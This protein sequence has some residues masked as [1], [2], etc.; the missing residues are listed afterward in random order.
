MEFETVSKQLFI[1][2]SP[3]KI[4]KIKKA[5]GNDFII[6]A[7]F[8]HV[9][10]LEKKELG[11]N[12]ESNFEPNYIVS[13]DKKNVVSELKKLGK[14]CKKV[15]LASDYDREGESIAWHLFQVMGLKKEN[16][17]RTV[18]TE[19]TPKAL[20]NAIK[21]PTDIDIDMFY[22]QQ[23][24]RVIDRLIG[25]LITPVLWKNFHS[26]FEKKISLSAGRVQTVALRIVKER[27]DEIKKFQ[28]NTYF[29]ITGQFEQI[30]D[31]DLNENINEK[32][33][34]S[35][36]LD[37]C[38]QTEF[39]ISDI[40]KK[41][42]IRKPSAPFITSSL[43]Q[44]A[45][46]KIGFSPKKTMSV[47]QRLYENGYITYMRT[48]SKILSNDA[49]EMISEVINSKYGPEYLNVTSYDKKVKGSQEAHEAIRP[50]DVKVEEVTDLEPDDNKLY[51]LIWKKTVASQ[52]SPAKVDTLTITIDIKDIE[53]IIEEPKL[54]FTSKAEAINFD[55]FM[56]LFP[57]N[58]NPELLEKLKK[59]KKKQVISY[60]QIEAA[61]KFTKPPHGYFTEASLIK[62]LEELG[63]GRPSTYSSII[64]TIQDRNYV[65]KEDRK[66]E[67]VEMEIFCLKD[68]KIST[69]KKTSIINKE[70]QKMFITDIGG[71]I[72]EFLTKHF[73]QL[74]DYGFTAKIESHL[75]DIANGKKVWHKV[76]KSVYQEFQP[77][78][79][80]LQDKS[81]KD[82]YKRVLENG[83]TVY[84][85]KY[86]PVARTNDDPPKFSPLGNFKIESITEHEA[87]SLFEFPKL[88]GKHKGKEIKLCNGKFGFY[89]KWN[90]KNFSAQSSDLTLEYAC[91][92]I[93]TPKTTN[94]NII[95]EISK[96]IIIKKGKYG[97]YMVYHGKNVRIPKSRIPKDLTLEDC[98]T[99]V[100]N[101]K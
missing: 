90:D 30:L 7:S 101:S 68:D 75:D 21:N 70:K 43:Q 60:D 48:D 40:K 23:A 93:E 20:Q 72:S 76:V 35:K 50:C 5:L 38:K 13:P 62:K 63:V 92:L 44:E 10:D 53:K 22:S 19:I 45:S 2:E 66:G 100:E 67:E 51:Q 81:E 46:N 56:K 18:F 42:S 71:I 31:A 84:I 3:S 36:F 59:F 78:I 61:Q 29:K 55:G 14:S 32:K 85:G 89:L 9:R 26:S 16:T 69:S 77:K 79:L 25:Y 33:D 94:S 57:I 58:D 11:I 34:V 28:K 54:Y 49:I 8:G 87:E 52:M 4:P 12:V 41:V 15:W 83:I 86:G 99:I 65:L 39:I 80:E 6:T 82:N 73:I 37:H 96:D 17:H 27:D 88:L 74:F 91:E 64:S 98:K 1:V 97:P 24:R 95:K 47:A